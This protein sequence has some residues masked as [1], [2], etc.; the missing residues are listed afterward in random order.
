[1]QV[2]FNTSD[3]RS[4]KIIGKDIN[5]QTLIDKPSTLFF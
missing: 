5:I 2:P 3:I 1:M 4:M